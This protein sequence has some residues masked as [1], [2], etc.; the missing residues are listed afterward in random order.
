PV[1]QAAPARQLP[2]PRG[3]LPDGKRAADLPHGERD[4]ALVRDRPERG[5]DGELEIGDGLALLAG[6]ERERALESLG[7]RLETRAEDVG[8]GSPRR[9]AGARLLDPGLRLRVGGVVHLAGLVDAGLAQ[10]RHTTTEIREQRRPLVGRW[11]A[12]PRLADR[13]GF[14]G[15][16]PGRFGA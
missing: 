16:Y 8:A 12:S 15:F 7:R 3:L 11:A 14:A 2:R 5:G 1:R 13:L 9:R 10:L 6:V 4:V